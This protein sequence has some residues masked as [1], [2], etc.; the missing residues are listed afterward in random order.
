MTAAVVV[1]VLVGLI[2]L[3]VWAMRKSYKHQR[4][5]QAERARAHAAYMRQRAEFLANAS[6]IEAQ[7]FLIQ[8]QTNALIETQR[9]NAV[10]L[11]LMIWLN[12]S[13]SPF[14]NHRHDGY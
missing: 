14:D 4:A 8:E 5:I 2:W 7:A 6:P 10:A 12:G 1:A 9:R 13:L 11:G 3:L